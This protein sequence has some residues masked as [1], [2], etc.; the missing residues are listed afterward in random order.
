MLTGRVGPAGPGRG[1]AGMA[2]SATPE[3]LAR[4]EQLPPADDQHRV[5]LEAAA[6]DDGTGRFRLRRLPAALPR[7][8]RLSASAS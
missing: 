7:A 1:G 5:D 4:L 2:L 3:L 6:A 8:A